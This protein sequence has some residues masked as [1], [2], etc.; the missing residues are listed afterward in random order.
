MGVSGTDPRR[1]ATAILASLTSNC[2]R[3]DVD[4]QLCLTQLLINLPSLPISDLPDWLPDG[5]KA[6][7]NMR[8]TGFAREREFAR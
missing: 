4:P 1:R 8:L 3:H 7:Q 2:R 6:A 5:W